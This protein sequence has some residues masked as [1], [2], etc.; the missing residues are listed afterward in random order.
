MKN[1]AFLAALMLILSSNFS[2]AD[3]IGSV[4]LIL[5]GEQEEWYTVSRNAGGKTALSVNYLQTKRSGILS[6]QAHPQPRFSSTE[7]LSI[8]VM[9]MGEYEAGKSPV[10]VEVMVHS[11]GMQKPFFTSAGVSSNP[12]LE[13]ENL[14]FE[15]S[16]GQVLGTFDATICKVQELYETPDM[17]DCIDVVGRFDSQIDLN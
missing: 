2:L 15:N 4:A 3:Q 12:T 5:N 9:F 13:I 11:E 6:L 7:V 1:Q 14:T 8:S 16:P 17:T 10:S